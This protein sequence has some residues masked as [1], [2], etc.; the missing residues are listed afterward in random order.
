[1]AYSVQQIKFELL[2]FIKEFGSDPAHWQVGTCENPDRDLFVAD[3]VDRTADLW[4]WKPA[5]S[6]A[7][8]KMVAAF[9]TERVGLEPATA[10]TAGSTVFIFKR[11]GNGI[12][13]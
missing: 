13:G 3:V 8:A 9:L 7:A 1:M 6:P 11:R 2:G 10:G 12:A 4:M 5:L